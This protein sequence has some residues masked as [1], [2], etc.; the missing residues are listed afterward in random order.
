M[1]SMKNKL[2]AILYVPLVSL[3]LLF[4]FLLLQ[5]VHAQGMPMDHDMS[6][7]ASNAKN[8]C[9]SPS[10]VAVLKEEENLPFN[11][12]D[13][14]PEP[15]EQTP[16]YSQIQTFPEPEK[17][18]SNYMSGSRLLRPPDLVKLYSNFQL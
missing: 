11:E 1:K 4:G 15:P 9:S 18:D 16:Y 14:E 2:K 17:P 8:C 3:F 13:D 10:S 6:G 5:S 7:P 12:Q